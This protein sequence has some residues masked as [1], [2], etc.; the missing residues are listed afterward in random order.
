MAKCNECRSGDTHPL[1]G[2]NV[3]C[4]GCGHTGPAAPSPTPVPEPE[5]EPEVEAA[6]D[7]KDE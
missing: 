6:D 5:V 2:D 1:G 3:C 4:I 7:E